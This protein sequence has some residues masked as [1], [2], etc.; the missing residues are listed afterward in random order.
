MLKQ[1]CFNLYD[2]HHQHG[3][4][5]ILEHLSSSIHHQLH[6]TQLTTVEETEEKAK[7]TTKEQADK[8]IEFFSNVQLKNNPDKAALIYNSKGKEKKIQMEVGGCVLET[9]ASEKLLGLTVNSDLNWTTHVDK[10]CTTLKQRIGLLRRKKHKV[11][12]NKLKIIAEAI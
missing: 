8:I 4:G 9:K 12:S 2:P 10:L 1:T 3:Q 6:D 5:L 11:N 7:E